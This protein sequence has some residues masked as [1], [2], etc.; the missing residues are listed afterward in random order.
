MRQMAKMSMWERIKMMTG[1]GQ[2]GAFKPGSNVLKKKGR[3]GAPQEPQ[4]TRQGTQE[5]EEK[6][7]FFDRIFPVLTSNPSSRRGRGV[8]RVMVLLL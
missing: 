2:A 8:G 5:E 7:R 1:L 3:H 6:V 4:G